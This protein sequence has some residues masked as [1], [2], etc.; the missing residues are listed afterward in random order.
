MTIKY[1]KC[2]KCNKC[3]AVKHFYKSKEEKYGYKNYCKRCISNI[4]KDHYILNRK[5]IKKYHIIYNL[6]HKDLLTEY[7]KKNWKDLNRRKQNQD[8]HKRWMIENSEYKKQQDAQYYL[9]NKEKIMIRTK[10]YYKDNKKYML[11]KSKEWRINNWE[12]YR[13][14]RKINKA[15]RRARTIKLKETFTTRQVKFI[16]N[17]FDNQCFNCNSK[18]KLTIDHF[19]PL[20]KGNILSFNNAI[21][22]CR[23]CNLSKHAKD[24]PTVLFSASIQ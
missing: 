8:R 15:R 17:V 16:F 11:L 9:D 18:D 4:R 7:N 10:N 13:A 6:N 22:L 20:S 5:K 19:Y 3:R 21:I 1:K 14:S 24:P 23:K 12:Q 2:N